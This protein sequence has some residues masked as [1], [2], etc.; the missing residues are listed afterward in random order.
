[1]RRPGIESQRHTGEGQHDLGDE[2]NAPSIEHIGQLSETNRSD[3][4]RHQL[5]HG[6]QS[7]DER[8]VGDIVGLVAQGHDGH[9]AAVKRNDLTEKEPPET[10]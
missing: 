2:Q 7:D 3:E 8:L 10:G 1:M 4:Q 9:L 6:E 5:R